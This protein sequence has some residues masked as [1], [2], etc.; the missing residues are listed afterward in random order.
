MPVSG[1]AH[2]HSLH[3]SARLL[4]GSSKRG[5]SPL[6]KHRRGKMRASQTYPTDQL[7]VASG[8][9]CVKLSQKQNGH[10]LVCAMCQYQ[11]GLAD[12]TGRL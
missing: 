8:M 7:G 12:G 6:H 9:Q 2:I 10:H 1:T 5:H 11:V 4:C 3:C